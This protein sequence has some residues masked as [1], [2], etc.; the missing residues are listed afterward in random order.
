[1]RFWMLVVSVL[2]AA[3][4]AL[5]GSGV[6][7]A[8]APESYLLADSDVPPG[9]AR[10]PEWDR[11]DMVE[12]A[13]MMFRGFERE[14]GSVINCGAYATPS[15]EV[16]SSLYSQIRDN[17]MAVGAVWEPVDGLGD[18]ALATSAFPILDIIQRVVVFRDETTTAV[19]LYTD[20][21]AEVAPEDAVALARIMA[22]N[23]R[24]GR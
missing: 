2:V 12:G 23:G 22:R 20:K 19:I 17:F 13:I 14:N 16:A 15:V 11:L 3:S 6:A 21:Q 10:L 8:S 9:F 18:E 5:M 4:G 1:M 24:A 7:R